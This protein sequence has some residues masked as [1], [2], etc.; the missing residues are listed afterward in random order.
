ML[1]LLKLRSWEGQTKSHNNDMAS[2]ILFP[3]TQGNTQPVD[4]NYPKLKHRG[5]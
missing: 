1:A 5:F 3:C 2:I 4:Y